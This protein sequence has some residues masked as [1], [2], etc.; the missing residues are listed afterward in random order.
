MMSLKNMF[1]L[2]DP[3]HPPPHPYAH[4]PHC[5][6]G[7]ELE[8]RITSSAFQEL[9]P[10]IM[11][12]GIKVL[13]IHN[14]FPL[15]DGYYHKPSGDI[16]KHSSL[17]SEE[18]EKA[19]KFTIQSLQIARELNAGVVVVHLGEVEMEHETE[20]L[21]LFL[22]HDALKSP[23]AERFIAEKRT[24]REKKRDRHLEAVS[25]T[26]EEIL[27]VAEKLGVKVGMENRYYYHQIPNHEEIGMLLERFKGSSLGYWHDVGHARVLENLG[28]WTNHREL[29]G[30]YG[31]D[32]LGCHLHDVVGYKDHQAPGCGEI[33]FKMVRDHIP[34]EAI[35]VLEVYPRVKERE[36]F[37]SLNM[38]KEIWI[39]D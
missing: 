30:E 20:R 22:D 19:V 13:S 15:P 21:K 5:P 2:F 24:E 31:P 36:L 39:E 27:V 3:R 7:V 11:K 6:L 28:G 26:L 35:K 10:Y 17:D 14:F 23:E 8:Y 33:D 1:S 38:L 34:A 4:L 12:K 25:R 18:R 9:R 29:L 37:S 32:I 16:Y